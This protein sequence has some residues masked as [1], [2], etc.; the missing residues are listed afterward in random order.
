MST[1]ATTS[2]RADASEKWTAIENM[3]PTQCCVGYLEV[4]MKMRELRER[5]LAPR[6]LEKYLRNHPIPAV[7]GPDSRMHLIDHHHM[8]LALTRLSSEW[9]RSSMPAAANPFRQCCF[10]IVRDYSSRMDMSM[11]MFRAELEAIGL[12]HPFG[13]DGERASSIPA[14]LSELLDDP[15]RSLAGLA[16]KAGAFDKARVP[17]AEFQWADYFRDKIP[18]KLIAPSTLPL[19]IER[20]AELAASPGA[21]GL[22]GYHGGALRA[23]IPSI[24][25]IA[26][27]LE[28]RHG[29][30]DSAPGLPPI[31]HA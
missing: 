21:S 30:D 16:R 7:L 28:L 13:P 4:A 2:V 17:Y 26:L 18:A 8:G 19:A 22:P 14:T 31:P 20:A 3:R 15:Y 10:S 11:A 12:C 27:R 6:K 23:A 29:S 5:S 25:E 9:D 24:E 1:P